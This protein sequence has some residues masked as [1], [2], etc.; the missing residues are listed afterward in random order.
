MKRDPIS[1]GR[2]VHYVSLGSAPQ[3]GFQQF[4]SECRAAIVT[5]VL[6]VS[7]G[8]VTLTV[9]NPTGFQ[10][11]EA[12]FDVDYLALGTSAT[13]GHWHWPERTSA[14]LVGGAEAKE[15]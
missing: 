3:N 11:T 13:P 4:P 9:F 2:I 7:S 15:L 12:L 5:S 10:F 14:P 8:L 6:D 1:V